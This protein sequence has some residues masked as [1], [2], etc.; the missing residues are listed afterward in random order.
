MALDSKHPLYIERLPDWQQME[1]THAGERVVKA[2]GFLYLKPTSGMVQDGVMVGHTTKGW[3]N[4]EAYRQRARCPD[5][6]RETV[7]ALIGVMW[8]KPPV[9]EVPAV[10]A[11]MIEEATPENESLQQLLRRLNEHQL[12]MG[13]CGLFGDVIDRGARAGQPYIALYEAQDTIN[14]DAGRRD[15]IEVQNLNLVVIDESGPERVRGFEWENV[16]KWRVLML[17]TPRAMADE[18]QE[19]IDPGSDDED[20][21]M[22]PVIELADGEGIYTAGV[23]RESDA[24]FDPTLMISPM[25]R[26]VQLDEIPFVFVN[27][28]DIAAEPDMPP[29]LALSNAVLAIYRGEADYRQALHML[30]QDTLVVIGSTD[31]NPQQRIGSG[32]KIDLPTGADAKFIGI[33]SSGVPEMRESLQ[34]DYERAD[35]QTGKMLDTTSREKESGEA[36]KIRVAAKT[37]TLTQIALTGAAALAR[38]LK[39]LARWAG[40]DPNQVIVTPNLEFADEMVEGRTVVEFTTAKTLGAPLSHET[41]HEIYQERGLTTLTFEEEIA[42]I[43]AEETDG[44]NELL[45]SASMGSEDEEGPEDDEEGD[46]GGPPS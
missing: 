11:P 26:G 45:R 40:G 9:I 32:A 27:S 29:L 18:Q 31:E 30:C 42:K 5:L 37:A 35:A 36:L 10:L 8:R 34:N 25:I 21:A 16:S 1:H 33:D 17:M 2:Q 4:Y 38:L 23:F 39:I 24:D 43:E 44:T 28:K 14:W 46:G 12:W 7:E 6:V 41:L 15:G 22:D 3:S 20:G 13:R 19:E